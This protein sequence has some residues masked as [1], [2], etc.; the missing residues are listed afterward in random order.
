MGIWIASEVGI[1]IKL[2][3]DVLGIADRMPALLAERR[4]GAPLR[5]SG[6]ALLYPPL[7]NSPP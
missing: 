2:R 7:N 5:N 4:I 6:D 1:Q 3:R